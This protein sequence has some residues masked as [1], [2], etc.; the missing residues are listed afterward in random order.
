MSDPRPITGLPAFLAAELDTEEVPRLPHDAVQVLEARPSPDAF[1]TDD[2]RIVTAAIEAI[3]ARSKD[4]RRAALT[5][6][7]W[8]DD[9]CPDLDEAKRLLRRQARRRAIGKPVEP[10]ALAMAEARLER[11]AEAQERLE[12]IACRWLGT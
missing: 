4:L 7:H 1:A 6:L 8:P 9:T 2:P 5:A 12:Q 11:V 10:E 3:R